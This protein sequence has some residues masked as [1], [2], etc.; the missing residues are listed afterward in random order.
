MIRQLAVV[1]PAE[2]VELVSDRLWGLGVL[3]IEEFDGTSNRTGGPSGT[4]CLVAT[5]DD[6]DVDR[7]LAA[8][9]GY[10]VSV[11]EIDDATWDGF[12]DAW[13]AAAEPVR[14]GSRVVLWPAWLAPPDSA[15]P[16]DLVVR[17]DPG[18]AFG[19]GSHPTTRLAVAALE[20]HLV[21]AGI[22]DRPG[23]ALGPRPVVDVGCGSGVLTVVAALLGARPVT[24]VDTDPAAIEA[25]QENAAANGV[26]E[27]VEI[28]HGSTELVP[29]ASTGPID[30]TGS[31]DSTAGSIDSTDSTAGS[32]DSTGSTGSIGSTGSTGSSAGPIVVANLTAGLVCELVPELARIAGTDGR[33]L[34]TGILD[35][36]AGD[37]AT[38]LERHGWQVAEEH[39]DDGWV[40]LDAVVRPAG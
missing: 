38:A 9:P 36:R 21:D 11:V 33:L 16:A 30:S 22:D 40:L 26:G 18:R 37:V 3:G 7:L 20:R 13:R 34:L 39:H 23:P 17:L 5:P 15:E 4:V 25:T 35:E 19:S 1:V 32:I 27:L 2:E 8:V 24:A 10:P 28:G 6:G 31:T 14:A 29:S 12:L